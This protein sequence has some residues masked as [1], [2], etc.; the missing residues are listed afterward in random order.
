MGERIAFVLLFADGQQADARMR[1]AV[2][3]ARKGIAHDGELSEHLRRESTLAPTSS[4]T[5]LPLR[6]GKAEASAG[7]STPGNMPCTILAVAMTA[8]VLPA[9]TTHCASPVFTRREAT[10]MELSFLARTALPAL[11]SIVICSEAWRISMG[12]VCQ[13]GCRFNSCRTTSSLP[14][15]MTL[16][17]NALAA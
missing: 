9:E 12:R 10:R 2:N 5:A 15:K 3:D 6:V 11:S 7:R 1:F 13:P 16:T 4:M 8:P 14:T 17:P